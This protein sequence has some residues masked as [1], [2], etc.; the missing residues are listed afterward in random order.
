[1]ARTLSRSIEYATTS[2]LWRQCPPAVCV[3]ANEDLGSLRSVEGSRGAA[4][5]GRF[6]ECD[7]L[8]KL[9]EAVAHCMRERL[10]GGEAFV[11]DASRIVADAHRRRGVAKVEDLAPTSR[12]A[13]A[14][15]FSVLDDAAFGGATPTEPKAIS[16]AGPLHRGGQQRCGVCLFRQLSRRSQTCGDH[17]RRSDDGHSA[18]GGRSSQDDARPHPRKSLTSPRRVWSPTLAT[19]RPRGWGDWWTSA[20]SSRT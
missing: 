12:R 8:R 11:A 1:M 5:C 19:A 15:Y 9:F 3:P 13:V 7:V 20:G 18:D 14:E 6:R 17:G 16:R 10:V 4:C 2:G